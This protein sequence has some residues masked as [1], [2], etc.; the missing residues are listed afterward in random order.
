MVPMQVITLFLATTLLRPE[1]QNYSHV[2]ITHKGLYRAR[3]KEDRTNGKG[4]DKGLLNKALHI[5]FI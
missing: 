3:P 1:P 2:Q 4:E 5:Y